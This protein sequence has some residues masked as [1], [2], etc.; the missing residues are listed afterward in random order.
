MYTK[1]VENHACI[2]WLG[3]NWIYSTYRSKTQPSN[4]V[5]LLTLLPCC[6]IAFSLSSNDLLERKTS[7]NVQQNEELVTKCYAHNN[8]C[9]EF[10]KRTDLDKRLHNNTYTLIFSTSHP[11]KILPYNTCI[12]FMTRAIVINQQNKKLVCYERN[13]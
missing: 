5:Y 7:N 10:L 8:S 9:H 6:E 2:V 11:Q 12:S 1:G 3:I 13:E 4:N